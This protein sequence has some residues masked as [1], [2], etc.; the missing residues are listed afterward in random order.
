MNAGV[1]EDRLKAEQYHQTQLTEL[2]SVTAEAEGALLDAEGG[3]KGSF[4]LKGSA[5]PF[6][7]WK[8]STA[9]ALNGWKGSHGLE[10]SAGPVRLTGVVLPAG[11]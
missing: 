11:R 7:L 2:T 3:V 1:C 10:G 9:S 4:P 6:L 5:G 8:G